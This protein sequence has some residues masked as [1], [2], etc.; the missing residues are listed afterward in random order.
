[1]RD[2]LI[3]SVVLTTFCSFAGLYGQQ[4]FKV[5]GIT[6][7][8]EISGDRLNCS[9]GAPTSGWIG[10]GFNDRNSIV[11]SDLLLFN[12]ID[13][14]AMASD[15]FVKEFGNPARD[16]DLGG[17]NNITVVRSTENESFTK[18]VFTIPIRSGDP[19]DFVHHLGK[20]AWLILAY[21][22]SDDFDHHSRVRKHV[23]F[24]L[25]REHY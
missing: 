20:K 13:G 17:E 3:F 2:R 6:F 22:E 18:F 23:A 19:N 10:V 24:E 7:T 4:T 15:L 5:S 9:L 11:G 14:V 1:M 25:Q 8:Y 16:E 12:S 21:S